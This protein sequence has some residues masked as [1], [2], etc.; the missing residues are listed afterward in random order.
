MKAIQRRGVLLASIMLPFLDVPPC[1]GVQFL[2]VCPPGYCSNETCTEIEHCDGI[3]KPNGS[4]CGCCPLC[5]RL[6]ARIY[7]GPVHRRIAEFLKIK[8]DPLLEG[9]RE[10]TKH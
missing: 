2:F 9:Q 5:V 1:T 6:L 8:L 3:V 7:L 10:T 4:T